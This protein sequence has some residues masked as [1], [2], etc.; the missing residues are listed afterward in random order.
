[1]FELLHVRGN[2]PFL[3]YNSRMNLK[4]WQT[5]ISGIAC[6]VAGVYLISAGKGIGEGS[7][8]VFAGIGLLRAKDADVHSTEGEV[9]IATAQKVQQLVDSENAK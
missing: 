6:I 2:S 8:L 7:G 1:M 9:K 3:C 5:T 4:S